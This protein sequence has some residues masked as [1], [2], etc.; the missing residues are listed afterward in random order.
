MKPNLYLGIDQGTSSTKGILLDASGVSVAEWSAA[1]PEAR[2]DERRVE[3]DPEGILSSVVDIFDKARQLAEEQECVIRGAGFG[4]QRSGVLAWRASDGVSVHPM[5]TWADTRTYPQIQAFGRGVEIISGKTGLPT[6]PN[7]AAGK[8]HLLQRQFLDPQV[9][10]G[11]LDSFL[12]FRLSKGKVFITEDTMASRTMLYA[13]GERNWSDELCMQFAVDK[14]RLPRI[15]PSLAPHSTHEGVPIVALLGDQQAALLGR[16]NTANRPLL[17]LG[18]IAS[19]TVST[20]TTPVQKPALK[21]SVLYSRL[22]PNAAVRDLFFLSEVT[23]SVTGNVLLEP[24]RRAWCK[25]SEELQAQCE[26]SFEANPMGLATAYFVHKQDPSEVWPHGI[27]NV[28]VCK[29][30]AT[31]ADR[32]RAV[33]ENVGNLIVRMLEQFAEKEMLGEAFPAQIDLA[34]GG[35][36]ID[37]LVQYVADV[38]GHTFHR[39]SARE[40]GARGAALAALT[41]AHSRED[42]RSFNA[43]PATRVFVCENPERRKRYLVWQ[44]MEQDVLKNTLPPHAEIEE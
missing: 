39:F 19:L 7:F 30:G 14:R 36:E 31:V 17:T 5:M 37:Y 42:I 24:L 28:M 9:H 11:T 43:E 33:V 27:P 16:M 23:S 20:G 32:A 44:R 41:S 40:A 29:S 2:Y 21:T 35:S 18:T 4:V 12:L 22:I 6:I 25:S 38:S 3:Q 1:V 34:G 8:I 26:A 15:N 13:L 10:V